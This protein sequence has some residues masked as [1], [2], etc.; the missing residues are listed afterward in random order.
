MTVSII[1]KIYLPFT[2]QILD[3]CGHSY[4]SFYNIQELITLGIGKMVAVIFRNK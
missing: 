3:L 1:L 2:G 4:E